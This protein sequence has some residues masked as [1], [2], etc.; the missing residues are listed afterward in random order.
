MKLKD[1]QKRAIFKSLANK[2]QFKTGVEFGLDKYYK[3]NIGVISRVNKIYREVKENPDKF[4]VSQE[5]VDVVEKGM[6]E[7]RSKNHSMTMVKDPGDIDERSLVIGVKNKAWMLLDQK[8]NYLTRNKRAFRNESIQKLAWIAGL[9]FDKSQI[10]K[11]EATEHIALKAKIDS[12][13]TSED[14][15]TQL[16]KFREVVSDDE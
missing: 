5:L 1:T 3:G 11:G 12:N 14:A 10:V 16:L 8:L 6:S 7:R 4:A 9:T 2:G 15:T 13:I